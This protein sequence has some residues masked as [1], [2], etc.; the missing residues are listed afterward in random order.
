MQPVLEI[1]FD[2]E[3]IVGEAESRS[4]GE[5]SPVVVIRDE[6]RDCYDINSR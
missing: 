2:T 3:D 4:N 6:E 1:F 5:G